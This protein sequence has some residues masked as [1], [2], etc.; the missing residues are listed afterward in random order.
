MH[1][2]GT[3]TT[4]QQIIISA[5][6]VMILMSILYVLSRARLSDGVRNPGPL[7]SH[8][9][10]QIPVYVCSTLIAVTF[11]DARDLWIFSGV[12]DEDFYFAS[13][14]LI[15]GVIT[16]CVLFVLVDR[17][18]KERVRTYRC[19]DEKFVCMA[20]CIMQ[21][22]VLSAIAYFAKGLPI[23]NAFSGASLGVLRHD[24]TIDFDGPVYL[25]AAER[26]ISVMGV[27]YYGVLRGKGKKSVMLY[28]LLLISMF[29][30]IWDGEKGPLAFGLL[31]VYF[32]KA[33]SSRK[34]INVSRLVKI[35]VG[36]GG[37]AVAMF[38]LALRG[39]SASEV[40]SYLATRLFLGQISGY[41]QAY[42]T[43]IPDKKYILSWIPFSGLLFDNVPSFN[44]DLMVAT[45]G[46][47]ATNGYM[48]S[49]FLHEAYGTLG[50]FGLVISPIVV[51]LSVVIGL[52]VFR[53]AFSGLV[54]ANFGDASM[55]VVMSAAN[56]TGGF[57]GFPFLRNII[58]PFGILTGVVLVYK[59]A[60]DV[61]LKSVTKV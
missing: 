56:L 27:A 17:L 36:A 3:A 20:L 37:A 4:L 39:R 54:G 44:R 59:S 22:L 19:E 24:A 57:S 52:R 33:W 1:L 34:S 30:L 13:L 53:R 38:F 49:I 12:S 46:V 11:F 5:G 50:T 45:Q 32:S 2:S 51:A 7:W 15:Y 23:L 40:M 60:I 6:V 61:G 43:F 48:N 47:T 8:F 14:W 26:T 18:W 21:L 55:F 58:V 28:T 29:G 9:W 25:L 31:T 35:I 42:A 16:Y 10:F 41:Y